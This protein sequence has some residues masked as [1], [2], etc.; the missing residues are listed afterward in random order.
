MN[1]RI[2]GPLLTLAMCLAASGVV[3]AQSPPPEMPVAIDWPSPVAAPDGI[4]LSVLPFGD[5]LV[6]TGQ[7]QDGVTT[8]AA[9]WWSADGTLVGADLPPGPTR[10]LHGDPGRGRHA[11]RFP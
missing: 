5:G 11:D 3:A 9:A 6:A 7:V 2:G 4:V 1:R 10:G 8:R